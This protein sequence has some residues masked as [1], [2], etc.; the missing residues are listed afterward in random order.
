MNGTKIILQRPHAYAS[1]TQNSTKA[2]EDVSLSIQKKYFTQIF[3][4]DLRKISVVSEE[5]NLTKLTQRLVQC[6]RNS[7]LS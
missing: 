7:D 2:G 4:K 5:Q 3:K 6:Q 1:R